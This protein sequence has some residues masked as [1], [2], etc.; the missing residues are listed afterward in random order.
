MASVKE[1]PTGITMTTPADRPDIDV[2]TS[3]AKGSALGIPVGVG[4][5][6][7]REL[8]LDRKTLTLLGF[9]GKP[10]QVLVVSADPPT[11]A[12]GIGEASSLDASR[13]RDAAAAF[14]RAVPRQESLGTTLTALAGVEAEVA[15]Q[16]V[17]EGIMLARYTYSELKSKPWPVHLLALSLTAPASRLEGVRRGAERGRV[18]AE[19]AMFARDLSN[20]PPAYLTATRMAE[21]ATRVA[22]ETGLKVEVFD[23]AALVRMGCGGLLGV[24]A[25]STE[26]AR[27]IKL[28]YAPNSGRS[29]KSVGHLTF[30]GKGIMYDSGGIRL[31]PSDAVNAR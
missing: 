11:V 26:P 7:P 22:R 24:N 25:G 28:T 8:G 3:P 21:V 15:G 29:S 5:T 18:Y 16:T 4:G 20:A 14:A 31:K 27:M 9:D 23:K 17:V 10:G 6:V 12:I 13:L 2:T 1:K 30:V 19:A